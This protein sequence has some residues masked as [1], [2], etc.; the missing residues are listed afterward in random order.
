[1]NDSTRRAL[2][3]AYQV[4]IAAVTVIPALAAILF[5]VIPAGSPI[6]AKAV[7]V[8]AAVVAGAAVV[9]KVLNRLEDAHLFPA[10][11]KAGTLTPA[12]VTPDGVAVITDVPPAA[13][14]VDAHE[15]P[16]AAPTT[17]DVPPAATEAVDPGPTP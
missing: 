7:A 5:E 13:P 6:G 2:R 8:I 15:A 1:M 14:A 9:T 10:W 12:P 17:P 4:L 11:L 3:T 16:A